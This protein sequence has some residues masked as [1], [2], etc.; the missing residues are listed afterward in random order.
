VVRLRINTATL[1]LEVEDHG[2][3]LEPD[4]ARQGLGLVAMRERAAI[5]GGTLEFNRPSAGGTR[6]HLIVPLKT[7]AEAE[8]AA[9]H[10]T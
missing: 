8:A 3:G 9:L 2:K 1:E 7:A 10:L 5:V 6:V 4:P